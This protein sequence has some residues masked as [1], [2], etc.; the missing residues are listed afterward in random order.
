M[1]RGGIG[2]YERSMPRQGFMSEPGVV[3]GFGECIYVVLGYI[4]P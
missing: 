4:M 1:A 3:L 2:L